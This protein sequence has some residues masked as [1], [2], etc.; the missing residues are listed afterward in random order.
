KIDDES[1]FRRFLDVY[2]AFPQDADGWSPTMPVATNP[3]VA[4]GEQPIAN[5]AFIANPLAR[6]WA[7][8]LNLRYR[9]LMIYLSHAFNHAGAEHHVACANARGMLIHRT[10]GEMYNIRAIAK[11]L[12]HLPL[13]GPE[14][15][16]RAG[17]P[18]EMPYTVHLPVDERD[19]WRLH[20]DLLNGS[21]T[22]IQ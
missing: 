22:L 21:A 11:I 7:Q 13:D 10:F 3:R 20:L 15:A 18:F 9:M 12:V 14:E 5:T 19:C 6:A 4:G 16:T 2:R 17:P 8:L 1:H